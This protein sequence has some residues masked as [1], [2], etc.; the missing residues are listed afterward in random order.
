M[1]APHF[2]TFYSFKGGVGRSMSLLN[3][4][5]LIAGSGRRVLM[6]DL[7]LEAPGLTYLIRDLMGGNEQTGS[8]WSQDGLSE[9]IAGFVDDPAHWDL[10]DP[11]HPEN[12]N[13]YLMDLAIP[14]TLRAAD[15]HGRLS[16]LPAGRLD[17]GYA[18]R[19]GR[20]RES[21]FKELRE[22][23]AAHLRGVIGALNAFDYVLIDSRTGYSDEGYLAVRVLA[24]HLVVLSGLNDQNLH[25][26]ANFLRQ[27][28]VWNQADQNLSRRVLLVASPVPEW[29]DEAKDQRRRDARDI[30]RRELGV[31]LG[32]SHELPYHPQLA[33]KELTVVDCLPKSGLARAYRE[34]TE[35]LRGLVAD[36]A[37][38]WANCVSNALVSARAKG[39]EGPESAPWIADLQRSLAEL[40]SQD[41]S[42]FRT[43]AGSA[44]D[45]LEG[46][47]KLEEAGPFLEW[48]SSVLPDNIRILAARVSWFKSRDS[49]TAAEL[50]MVLLRRAEA[51]ERT[52]Y[53][54][55]ALTL[56]ADLSEQI[57]SYQFAYEALSLV[58]ELTTSTKDIGDFAW[59]SWRLG[60]ASQEIGQVHRAGG[61][62]EAALSA[63]RQCGDHR[64]IA[65]SLYGLA[66]LDESH[67]QHE[68]A[69]Q[70]LS[71]SLHV[72]Q[73]IKSRDVEGAA[74]HGLA[75]LDLL[76]GDYRL[77]RNGF[78]QSL[79][80]SRD[81]GMK[82]N[83]GANL[84]GLAQLD[85]IQGAYG[86][87]RERLEIILQTYRELGR[88]NDLAGA[89][90]HLAE[91]DRQ[92]HD[93]PAAEHGFED[94]AAIF[95]E[96]GSPLEVLAAQLGA[97]AT[98]C[99]AHPEIDLQHL[100]EK[101]AEAQAQENP[102]TSVNANLL[103]AECLAAREDFAAAESV[104]AE[105]VT[106]AAA[107]GLR[108]YEADG[109]AW[110]AVALEALERR[111]EARTQAA[112]ALAF[113]RSQDVKA[114]PLMDLV[115][116][117]SGSDAP[118]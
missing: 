84:M 54:R 98:H 52:S 29:E 28:Q 80:I 18:G 1:S 90:H 13:R 15:T 78:V 51:I 69:R 83:D 41:P 11:E 107:L 102:V 82:E 7:D 110:C 53:R 49:A 4:A 59:I 88:R 21:A 103:L 75:R 112:Q 85:R 100:H 71:E 99:L 22:P 50:L 23:W 17:D 24:D 31:D 20:L 40:R 60:W 25:G 65:L 73:E 33:L 94:A 56:T 76:I 74:L 46:R 5:A 9:L 30:F 35:M 44:V 116:V 48:L 91:L 47:E 64:G 101:V 6:I 10:G 72:A 70:R 26:T 117:L 86:D 14:E 77:A 66:L 16:L 87:A 89:L 19:L 57:G 108:G 95:R 37:Q 114:H 118:A 113:F 42:L 97:A 36:R 109:R 27:L 92:Q 55:A 8:L 2:F 81:L 61:H 3:C 79:A 45:A 34:L 104:A 38:D 62:Y 111:N 67:A 39:R 63:Y 115:L 106:K 32:F 93:Y 43:L 68:S 96:L 58:Q 105:A 12:L